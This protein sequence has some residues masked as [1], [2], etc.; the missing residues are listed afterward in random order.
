MAMGLGEF[1]GEKAE[2]DYA[3]RELDREHWEFQNYPDGMYSM[4][5]S[6]Y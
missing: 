1:A 4:S 6:S 3:K 2:I 5:L